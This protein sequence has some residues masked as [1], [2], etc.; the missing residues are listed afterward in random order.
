MHARCVMLQQHNTMSEWLTAI[1]YEWATARNELSPEDARTLSDLLKKCNSKK[2]LDLVP[3]VELRSCLWELCET[4]DVTSVGLNTLWRVQTLL[5][6]Y[7]KHWPHN[8][9]SEASGELFLKVG[10]FVK[11]HHVPGGTDGVTLKSSI[12]ASN[13]VRPKVEVPR[14]ASMLTICLTWCENGPTDLFESK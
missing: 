8:G 13:Q 3:I 10:L 4:Q 7:A 2:D 14:S 5:D 9:S 11:S 12:P 6:K 1:V